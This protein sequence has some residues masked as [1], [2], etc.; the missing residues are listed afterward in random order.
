MY[1]LSEGQ[2]FLLCFLQYLEFEFYHVLGECAG[3]VAPVL[4]VWEPLQLVLL[5]VNVIFIV[6]MPFGG[7]LCSA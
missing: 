4:P 5:V 2:V 7:V 1:W 6:F 3:A